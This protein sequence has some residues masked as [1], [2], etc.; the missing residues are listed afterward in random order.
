MDIE[1][2][3]FQDYSIDEIKQ[4]F[5]EDDKSYTCLIC[6]ERFEKGEIYSFSDR[7]YEGKKAIQLHIK[8]K[9][10]SV[11][12]IL[13]NMNANNM[14]I[15]DLQLQLLNFFAKGLSDKEIAEYLGVT[16]ST[17]RNHRHKL[18][19][20]ERQ[21]KLFI[22]LMEILKEDGFGKTSTQLDRNRVDITDENSISDRERKRILDRYMT[23]S[24]RLKTYPNYEKS[25]RVILEAILINF[26]TE[27]K[28]TEEQVH[29]I[30][31]SIYG[32]YK[33]L[34]QELIAY[35]YLDRTTTGAIYWIKNYSKQYSVKE[36]DLLGNPQVGE[37]CLEQIAR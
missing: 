35:N 27:T 16:G 7:L 3:V 37:E 6:G 22:S 31:K 12:D 9:H 17:I 15:S 34:K 20:R 28:Y 10:Q 29:D 13:L 36:N 5:F 30:L 8:Y 33:L 21:N 18:K 11:K 26:C 4:G 2:E 24:G 25:R 32:D 1:A 23:A 19:E 14:G